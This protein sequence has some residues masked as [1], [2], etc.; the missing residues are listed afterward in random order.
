MSSSLEKASL[1]DGWSRSVVV[2]HLE[3]PYSAEALAEPRK[4]W[5]EVGPLG[6]NH[7]DA[8][9]PVQGHIVPIKRED[10]DFNPYSEPDQCTEAHVLFLSAAKLVLGRRYMQTRIFFDHFSSPLQPYQTH[11][12]NEPH[13][14]GTMPGGFNPG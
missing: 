13:M 4:D 9:K 14:D 6:V 1:P 10:Q 7:F 3:N 8:A 11:T 2:R 5:I 12:F